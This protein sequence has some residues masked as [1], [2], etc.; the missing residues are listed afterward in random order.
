MRVTRLARK[1]NPPHMTTLQPLTESEMSIYISCQQLFLCCFAAI[2]V[3]RVHV[4]TRA[5]LMPRKP[6][7]EMRF[8]SH[9]SAN[10]VLMAACVM[11]TEG[12]MEAVPVEPN[13]TEQVRFYHRVLVWSERKLFLMTD[14]R[15]SPLRHPHKQ[16]NYHKQPRVCLPAHT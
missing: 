15:R 8:L 5:A 2:L 11:T 12:W 6:V 4:K 13:V 9:T 1:G 3:S 10:K 7:Y 16:D 14:K